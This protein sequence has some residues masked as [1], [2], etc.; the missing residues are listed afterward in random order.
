MRNARLRATFQRQA[1]HRDD[2]GIV[3]RGERVTLPVGVAAFGDDEY[4]RPRRPCASAFVPESCLAAV[5]ADNGLDGNDLGLGKR[6]RNLFSAAFADLLTG[7][8]L[9][10]AGHR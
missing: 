8:N 2:D 3:L 5:L 6:L 7:R 9:F 1:G 4:M 10:R